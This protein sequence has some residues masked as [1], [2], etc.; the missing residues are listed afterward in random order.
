[1]YGAKTLSGQPARTL[2]VIA[3]N[4]TATREMNCLRMTVA[5]NGCERR[6]LAILSTVNFH[7][8]RRAFIVS[9]RTL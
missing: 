4:D 9:L 2:W 8:T 1:M 6:V 5:F 3:I 7:S